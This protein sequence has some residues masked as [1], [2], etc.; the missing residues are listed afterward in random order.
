MP[1]EKDNPNKACGNYAV[2]FSASDLI[3]IHVKRVGAKVGA[4]KS[5][6]RLFTKQ[7]SI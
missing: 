1:I 7:K 4:E 3:N 5:I 2:N 6:L